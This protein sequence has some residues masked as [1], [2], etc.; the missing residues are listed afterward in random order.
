MNYLDNRLV[1]LPLHFGGRFIFAALPANPALGLSQPI[2]AVQALERGL[3]A[4]Y[5]Q[6]YGNPR[7]SFGQ[8]DVSVFLQDEWRI[9]KKLAIKPGVRYQKQFWPDAPYDVSNVGGERLQYDIRQG[10]SVRAADR[11]GLRSGGRWPN[12]DPR[13]VRAVRRLSDPGERRDRPDRQRQLRCA[14]AGPAS[15]R[16]DCRLER[17]RPPAPRAGDGVSERGDLDDARSE[18]AVRDAHGCGRRSCGRASHVSLSANF[19]HVR[20]R[21]Q[22]G[23]IDYNPIV[24]SLGPGRRPNDVDG[25]AGTSASV[26]QYTSFGETWYRG[27]TVSLN[28]RFSG[29]HQF[30]ASYTLSKAEDNSTDF[31][32]AFLP[33]NNG[34]GRNPANPTGL[35]LGFDPARERGPA[36]HDQRHR[37][38]V[39]G[40]YQLPLGVQVAS[41]VTAASGRPFTPLAGADLNGDGDGGA[42]PPDRARRNPADPASSVGRN[43]ET[44]P[45]QVTVD[46]R[47]SKRFTVRG[48]TAMDVIAEAFNLFNRS[49]FSEV[50]SIF[51]RGAYPNEPQR[52]AQGRVT[53]GLFEQALPPRQIQLALRLTF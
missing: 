47:V 19:I 17:S 1:A 44:M 2:S 38:V 46:M 26:L 34:V 20:G 35:P 30:L 27:L 22:L 4:A 12:V 52:D 15:S 32:S 8:S 29:Q 25:R 36:T 3:P 11:R 53:Y 40:L 37:L 5:I 7:Y 41:I 39:S 28:K 6:G 10:G 23:T 50:N 21:H 16:I 18:G 24:P 14:H 42:F 45:A 48:R 9:G 51:G 43:S 31:Q 33:E 49:N 13:R